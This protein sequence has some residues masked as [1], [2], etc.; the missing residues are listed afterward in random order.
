M[1][2]IRNIIESM[3]RPGLRAV[4]A[5][6]A[7]WHARQSSNEDVQVLFDKV[8]MHRINGRYW[9][10]A[11]RFAYHRNI[12]AKWIRHASRIDNR[13][14]DFWFYDYVPHA[15]DVIVDVGA[16][17]GSDLP[18]FSR[19]VGHS[20]RILAIEAHPET[21]E[22][23]DRT[24]YW[25]GLQNVICVNNAVVDRPQRVV[26]TCHD[27]HYSN[28]IQMNSYPNADNVKVDGLRLDDIC[29]EHD[30]EQI[31]FLKINIEGAERLAI[32]GMDHVIERTR[33][34]CIACHD[35]RSDRGE[36]DF[37]RTK[38]EVVQFLKTNDFEI[39]IRT[40]DER[41]EVRDHVYG[42]NRRKFD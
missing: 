28:V 25:N 34:V 41:D 29:L 8:W 5:T 20:G 3:D 32:Q 10:D 31:D 33:Y 36:D 17:D 13:V 27:R 38:Q 30:I 21:F 7:T 12:S 6:Y 22:L 1:T 9:A 37:F 18:T 26:M 42:R 15:G 40:N 19:S 24:T 4:L 16:G 23:L 39:T 35:F 11:T 2:L 14:N